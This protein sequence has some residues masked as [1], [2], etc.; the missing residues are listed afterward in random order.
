MT[1]WICNHCGEHFEVPDELRKSGEDYD[2]ITLVCPHCH[3][4]DLDQYWNVEEGQDHA[5]AHQM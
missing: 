1:L 5:S 4:E 3:S 2:T